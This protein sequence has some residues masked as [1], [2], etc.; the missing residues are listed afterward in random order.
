[1]LNFAATV[2]TETYRLSICGNQVSKCRFPKAVDIYQRRYK[3]VTAESDEF[4]L[5]TFV[6]KRFQQI[7]LNKLAF[8]CLCLFFISQN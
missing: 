4:I 1:M 6:N 3:H 2:A 7:I 8:H 5:I